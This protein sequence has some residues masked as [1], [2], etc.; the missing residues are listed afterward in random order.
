MPSV[1]GLAISYP[2]LNLFHSAPNGLM[3]VARD[4]SILMYVIPIISRYHILA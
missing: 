2:T 1:G 3:S 4:F